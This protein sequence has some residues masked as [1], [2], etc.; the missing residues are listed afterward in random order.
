MR[1]ASLLLLGTLITCNLMARRMII[2]DAPAMDSVLS[3]TLPVI[4]AFTTPF[5]WDYID[6][7]IRNP[8]FWRSPEDPVK[9]Y[10]RRLL[11]HA[12][13]PF[14]S[15]REQLSTVDFGSIPVHME[16]PVESEEIPLR[17]INDTTFL[18][19]PKG[20]NMN[21]YMHQEPRMP[22]PDRA[23]FPLQD[24]A[25]FL[26]DSMNSQQDTT[27]YMPDSTIILPDSIMVTVLDT[28]AME[29][30]GITLYHYVNGVVTPDLYDPLTGRR[31]V[32]SKDLSTVKFITPGNTWLADKAS[33]FFMLRG[34]HQLDSLQY[35][36]LQ[37][38]EFT[39]RRD[40]T[41]L[42][43]NDIYGKS[44]P[45]WLTTGS[46][47]VFRY[48]IKNYKNDSIS[49]WIGNP[50]PRT[51]SLMLEDDVNVTRLKKQEISYLSAFVKETEPSLL[52]MDMLEPSPIFWDY[53]V[54]SA[55]VMNQTHLSN[56]TK[57]GESSF[58]TMM[59]IQ[60]TATYN[61]KE[62]S[63]QWINTA[64]LKFGTIRTPEKGFRKNHDSFELNSKF[65]LNAWGKIGMSASFY[66][67]NQLAKGYNYPND[68]IPV[69]KFLNP[70]TM[71]I[72]LGF[73]VKPYT[74]TTVNIAPLSY[75]T[76]FVKDTAH[77]DQTIHGIEEG[78]TAKKELGTQIVIH[79]KISP[80][81]GL[82]ITNHLRLFSNYLNHPENIDVD[83]E[84]M[85]DKKINWFFTI[86]LNLHLIYDDD[87]KFTV[88]DADDQ[89]ILLPDGSEKRVAK[90]QFK[91]F[92]GLS[93]QFKL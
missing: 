72:G 88:F 89:A 90:A 50:A 13:Q 87:V 32:F 47:D 93:L 62:A 40:S 20:W 76:T 58:S 73:E 1:G 9:D 52:T 25:T 29:S 12:L 11:D 63:T 5:A 92:L 24:S 33:P 53:A 45:V 21:L 16:E 38:L 66:M 84:M 80:M 81:E 6:Q 54:V 61:N 27:I 65:N 71:T 74:A 39:E 31:S 64:R 85:L 83:W 79:N 26:P 46:D 37:L 17:W 60:G 51:L 30:L 78:K 35:A 57:G 41:R 67:K 2:P 75:K 3:D 42:L 68:S 49:L 43:I 44:T 7:S 48:W 23:Q 4:P 56:W 28:A 82:D 36:V 77:I 70:G 15:V 19:D 18:M 22:E 10:L 59:D 55:F 91:E 34:E 69:S 86:R 8:E 14:D